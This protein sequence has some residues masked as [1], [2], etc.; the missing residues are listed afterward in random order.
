MFY[1]HNARNRDMNCCNKTITQ[2]IV[3]GVKGLTKVALGIDIVDK[4]TI[5]KRRN[6]C[7]LCD[8]ASRSNNPKFNST[9]GLTNFSKCDLCLCFIRAKTQLK[10]EQ[11]P[12][13]LW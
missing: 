13:K 11:C 9:N 10:T 3:N 2:T 4:E 7:R 8:H 6:E 1:V 12:L 5:T